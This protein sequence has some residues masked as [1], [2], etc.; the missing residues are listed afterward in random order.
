MGTDFLG[1][2]LI[3]DGYYGKTQVLYLCGEV[4]GRI[5]GVY[6]SGYITFE[7]PSQGIGPLPVLD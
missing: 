7:D 3:A 5:W 6:R 4:G 1:T 2:V